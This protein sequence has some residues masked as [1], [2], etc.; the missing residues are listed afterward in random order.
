MYGQDSTETR[1]NLVMIP[2]PSYFPQ[3]T[4]GIEQPLCQGNPLTVE[5]SLVLFSTSFFDCLEDGT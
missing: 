2:L 3:N 4:L 1:E 5:Y